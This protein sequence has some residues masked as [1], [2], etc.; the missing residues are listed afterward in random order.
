MPL[1]LGFTR[2][3]GMIMN[4]LNA[5]EF[6]KKERSLR[7]YVDSRRPV[8]AQQVLQ[9]IKDFAGEHQEHRQVF[10]IL[11]QEYA[12]RWESNFG[13]SWKSDLMRI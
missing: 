7:R 13:T 3:R 5:D 9:E 6:R 12:Q 11:R 10:E 8:E 4:G 2:Y 1:K